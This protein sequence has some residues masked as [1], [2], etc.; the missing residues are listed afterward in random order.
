MEITLELVE[1]LRKYAPVSYTLAKQALEHS[2]GNLLDALIY[3]EETGA[4]PRA[5]DCYYST[6]TQSEGQTP[7]PQAAPAEEAPKKKRRGLG[8]LLRRAR[9]WLI[10]NELEI[11]HKETPITSLPMLILLLLLFSAYFV[12]I[13]ILLL[14]P[15]FGFRYRFSGPDLE[16][17]SINQVMDTMADT[18]ADMGRQVMDEMEHRRRGGGSDEED[19]P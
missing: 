1:Q 18:A 4:I 3:L 15:F 11:W 17:E 2:D 13:P 7:P 6:R 12:V 5:E 16:R 10:D 19:Q 9:F 14:G 8:W